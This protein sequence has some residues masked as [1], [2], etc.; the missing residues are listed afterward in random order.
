MLGGDWGTAV[1]G[2]TM[3]NSSGAIDAA[4]EAFA[5]GA[6][7]CQRVLFPHISSAD[8]GLEVMSAKAGAAANRTRAATRGMTRCLSLDWLNLSRN[9]P[10]SKNR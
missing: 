7:I 8:Q 9:L 5:G 1:C 6:I 3:Y 10:K 2:A 4:L